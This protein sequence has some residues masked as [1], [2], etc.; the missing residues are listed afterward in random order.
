LGKKLW[1]LDLYNIQYGKL[2]HITFIPPPPVKKCMVYGVLV[3]GVTVNSLLQEPAVED[4]LTRKTAGKMAQPIKIRLQRV[5]DN[6]MDVEN[7]D[8]SLSV[9]YRV[10]NTPG[11][12]AETPTREQVSKIES[13]INELLN[14]KVH[15]PTEEAANQTQASQSTSPTPGPSGTNKRPKKGHY[16]EQ[17]FINMVFGPQEDESLHASLG[18]PKTG[19]E[20][21]VV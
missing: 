7:R 9:R 15:C 12:P 21:S 16:T 8:P 19:I 3:L 10:I 11:T 13:T 14:T 1:T 20:S 4:A 17:E 5:Q 6:P 2:S 18:S